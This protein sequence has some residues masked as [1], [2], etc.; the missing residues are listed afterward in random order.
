MDAS[1]GLRLIAC[2]FVVG[3]GSAIR[4]GLANAPALGGTGPET[5]VHDAI[6][7]DHD[8]CERPF[9]AE[10]A[11]Y[12]H[13][14]SCREETFSGPSDFSLTLSRLSRSFPAARPVSVCSTGL[15]PRIFGA[16]RSLTA[17]AVSGGR[18]WLSCD[19]D[20]DPYGP[21]SP[22]MPDIWQ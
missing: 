19:W 20:V 13:A 1:S 10:G 7:N 14:S 5:R 4:P 11:A 12:A 6:A 15:R 22:A 8:A 21:T 17:Y 9:V 3:C 18:L 16:E 2:F